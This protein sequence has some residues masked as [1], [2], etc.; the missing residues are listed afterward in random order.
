MV[1]DPGIKVKMSPY[2]APLS[3]RLV[4]YRAIYAAMGLLMVVTMLLAH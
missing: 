2:R 3:R 4:R 1:P